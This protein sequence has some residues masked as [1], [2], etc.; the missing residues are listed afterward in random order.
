MPLLNSPLAIPI[1]PWLY[2]YSGDFFVQKVGLFYLRE[3]LSNI[4]SKNNPPKYF[5]PTT[6]G[7]RCVPQ[8]LI[9]Q[10]ISQ[11]GL[12]CLFLLLQINHVWT[13]FVGFFT[14]PK[15]DQLRMEGEKVIDI[16]HKIFVDICF[17]KFQ[18][19]FGKI[20]KKLRVENSCRLTSNLFS[21]FRA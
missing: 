18:R 8:L 20:Y 15:T 6:M 2:P 21:S 1:D 7:G 5:L 16:C 10:Y 4:F 3:H 9:G 12:S 13:T 17:R 11:D 14:F 19:F